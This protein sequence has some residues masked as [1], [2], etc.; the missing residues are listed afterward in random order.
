M[1]RISGTW[2]DRQIYA[3][4]DSLV[5]N[6]EYIVNTYLRLLD[7]QH[8]QKPPCLCPERVVTDLVNNKRGYRWHGHHQRLPTTFRSSPRGASPTAAIRASSDNLLAQQFCRSAFR[9]VSVSLPFY[10]ASLPYS[11]SNGCVAARRGQVVSLL[12]FFQFRG[13]G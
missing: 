12:T 7:D 13:W 2:F 10:R 11:G 4:S 5:M 8:W 9:K 6:K 3:F 1:I